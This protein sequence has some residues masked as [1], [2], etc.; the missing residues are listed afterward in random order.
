MVLVVLVLRTAGTNQKHNEQQQQ[1]V[2]MMSEFDED[3]L[4]EE[5][6]V[7]FALPLPERDELPARVPI[8]SDAPTIA[9]PAIGC[10]RSGKACLE[11]HC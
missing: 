5:E 3:L 8:A 10:V 11:R 6:V 1:L 7:P 9:E 4:A 2:K